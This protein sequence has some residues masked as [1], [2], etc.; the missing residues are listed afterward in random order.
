MALPNPAYVAFGTLQNYFVDKDTGFP[1]AGGVVTFYRD[2]DRS[3]TGLKD[4]YEQV[5]LPGNIYGF[6]L[7]PNPVILSSVGTFQDNSGNDINVYGFPFLGTPDDPGDVDLYYITVDSA[8]GVRQFTR[9]AQPPNIEEE[10]IPTQE[11]AS[12]NNM[13]TN[14]QFVEVSFSTASIT[15]SYSYSVSG[16]NVVHEIAPGWSIVTGGTGNITVKQ[17]NVVDP[18]VLTNPPY[19]LDIT[20]TGINTVYLRQRFNN[21]PR[22]FYNDFLSG[23]LL[24]NSQDSS[25]VN[26]TMSLVPSSGTSYQIATGVTPTNGSFI[27]ITNTVQTTGI[28][29]TNPASTGY[30]DLII[31]FDPSHHIQITSVQL[32]SVSNVLDIISFAE[33]SS[34]RQV[35]NLFHYYEESVIEQTKTSILTGWD[36][37]LNPFQFTNPAPTALVGTSGYICDQTILQT[38][39][40]NSYTS[41]STIGAGDYLLSIKATTGSTSGQFALIQYIDANTCRNALTQKLSSLVRA[42][43]STTTGTVVGLKAVLAS[44]NGIPPN[45]SPISSFNGGSISLNSG[46]SKVLALN[47]PTYKLTSSL[48]KYSYNSF[49]AQA[50]I[51][52]NQTMALILYTTN[53]INSTS[54]SEDI[55]RFESVSLCP[56]DFAVEATPLTFDETLR[57]CQYYYETSYEVG[58]LPGSIS[59]LSMITKPQGWQTKFNTAGTQFFGAAYASSFTIEYQTVKRAIPSSYSIYSPITGAINNVNLLLYVQGSLYDS[60]DFSIGTGTISDNWAL[61]QIGTKT[62]SFDTTVAGGASLLTLTPSITGV[63]N[64]YSEL[65]AHYVIDARIGV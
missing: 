4:V 36:F 33:E 15:N 16:T 50:T 9:E 58:T 6:T 56:N 17:F 39:N 46:W 20:T 32:A 37:R 11:S 24:V 25:A 53:G 44:Y 2:L 19:A 54:G 49:P 59:N 23:Y 42:S 51:N 21:S 26:V 52:A 30:T 62:I 13:V 40:A 27:P 31:S 64:I 18:T 43:I 14:P 7:L 8:E 57:A 12:V 3:S 22:L 55:I 5:Q 45:T 1:L 28:G 41:Y 47:D 65:Y 60:G 29:N 63:P 34:D 38:Q 61:I 35:D 10:I 48:N